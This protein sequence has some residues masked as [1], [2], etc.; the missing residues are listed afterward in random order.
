MVH[1]NR[2]SFIGKAAHKA[3]AKKTDSLVKLSYTK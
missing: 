2:F 1:Q 3:E